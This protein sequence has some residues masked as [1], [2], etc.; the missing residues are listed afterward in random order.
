MRGRGQDGFT[1]VEV[2]MAV[3]ILTVGALG[4]MALQQASTRGNQQAREMT[5]ATERSRVWLERIRRDSLRWTSSLALD[6]TALQATEYLRQ[7]PA[8]GATAWLAPA[9]LDGLDA[10][11]ATYLGEDSSVAGEL[12]YC[13]HLRLSWVRPGDTARVEV[14]TFWRKRGDGTDSDF[15]DQRLFLDCGASDPE[16]VTAELAAAVP[17]L[18]SVHVSTILRWSPPG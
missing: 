16:A 12:H 5:T 6:P 9:S 2:M 18:R 1:L 14:R 8:A 13:T 3:S 15:S 4:I 7:L 11:G 17:R 10:Y